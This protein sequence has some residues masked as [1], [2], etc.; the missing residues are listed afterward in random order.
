MKGNIKVTFHYGDKNFEKLIKFI[1]SNKLRV[2]NF[3]LNMDNN[4]IESQKGEDLNA[5]Q[6]TERGEE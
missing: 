1:V 2:N 6:G 3:K 5:V 4:T